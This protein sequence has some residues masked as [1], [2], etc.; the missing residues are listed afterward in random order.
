MIMHSTYSVQYSEA[1]HLFYNPDTNVLVTI[2]Y[3]PGLDMFEVITS[4]ST[5]RQLMSMNSI[6][7]KR[8]KVTWEFLG[9][10]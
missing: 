3:R 2:Q 10:L 5:L 1:I 9:V 4:E 7:E 6:I 8:E